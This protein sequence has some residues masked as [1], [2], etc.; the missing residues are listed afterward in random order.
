MDDVVK[1]TTFYHGGAS[2]E[3]LHIILTVRSNTFQTPDPTTS[4]IPISQLAYELC[5]LVLSF[6]PTFPLPVI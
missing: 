3:A 6:S 4:H 5:A 2:A 1:V